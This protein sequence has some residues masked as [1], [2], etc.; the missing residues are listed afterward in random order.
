M[1]HNFEVTE[2]K[3]AQSDLLIKVQSLTAKELGE[4][5]IGLGDRAVTYSILQYDKI[6]FPEGSCQLKPSGNA[7]IT[8]IIIDTHGVDFELVNSDSL[9]EIIEDEKNRRDNSEYKDMPF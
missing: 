8:N 4:I 1:K 5:L 3:E 2:I 9:N 7:E 6:Y